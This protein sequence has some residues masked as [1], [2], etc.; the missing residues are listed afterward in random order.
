MKID[1]NFNVSGILKNCKNTKYQNGIIKKSNDIWKDGNEDYCL[2]LTNGKLL[3]SIPIE[4]DLNN[5][6]EVNAIKSNISIKFLE[7]IYKIGKKGI[8]DIV[9]NENDIQLSIKGLNS[10]V[11]IKEFNSE[12]NDFPKVEQIVEDSM[13]KINTNTVKSIGVNVDY[14][15]LLNNAFNK[16]KNSALKIHFTGEEGAMLITPKESNNDNDRCKALLMPVI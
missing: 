14:L 2:L 16:T 5:H 13:K 10:F 15:V 12:W 9:F 4:L 1:L 7:H 3:V 6:W 11:S 8:L